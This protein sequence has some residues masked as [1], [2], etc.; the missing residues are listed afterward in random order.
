M[1]QG[2]TFS[3]FFYGTLMH[4]AI[5]RRVIGH[6]GANLEICPALLLEHTRH[7]IKHADYPGVIPYNRT[8]ELLSGRELAPEDRTVRGTLVQ[9]LNEADVALLD[10]FEGDEYAREIVSVHPLSKFVLL[11]DNDSNAT[12]VPPKPPPVPP[13]SSLA[14]P[15]TAHIYI[16]TN[17]VSDLRPE[18]WEYEQFVRESASKW[19]GDGSTDNQ[20]YQRVDERRAMNGVIVRKEIEGESEGPTVVAIEAE[21]L[22]SRD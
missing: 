7:H 3:A 6:Q 10:I 15:H 11:A 2:D 21:P 13:L 14:P 1:A 22:Y 17:P 12:L 9:G 5:L 4:P 8:R 18:V 19:V 16:W 20:D